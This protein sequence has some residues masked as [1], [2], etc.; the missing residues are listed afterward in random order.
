MIERFAAFVRILNKRPLERR[1][2]S[3][4]DKQI[5]YWMS[6]CIVIFTEL[7]IRLRSLADTRSGPAVAG[8]SSPSRGTLPNASEH[9]QV[10]LLR[11]F[12]AWGANMV[13]G[14]LVP[15]GVRPRPNEIR[16]S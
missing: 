6:V 16:R 8:L 10:V 2:Q 9:R 12:A 1:L 7:G 5:P 15:E 11:G 4:P 13:Q 14:C 3:P